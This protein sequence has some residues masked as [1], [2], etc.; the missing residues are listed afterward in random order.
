MKRLSGIAVAVA[1]LALCA[2]G[3]FAASSGTSNVIL[4]A[5]ANSQIQIVDASVTLSPTSADYDNGFVQI[6][7]ASGLRVDVKTNSS[8]GVVLKVK[9]A[10]AVPQIALSDLLVR[11]QTAPGPGG[12]SM[13]AF[14]AIGAADQNLWSSLGS[15]HNW[16]EVDTDIKIQNISSYDDPS[17]GGP[18]NYTNTLTY[19]VVSL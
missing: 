1:L 7:G 17:G 6:T 3:A 8:T 11:T 10:D 15:I 4:A 13:A 5:S 19:T 18:T 16:L 2:S 14:T 12:S 9:C